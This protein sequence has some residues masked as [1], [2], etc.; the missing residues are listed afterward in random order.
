MNN[1]K[2]KNAREVAAFA[3]YEIRQN[4]CFSENALN[5]FLDIAKL[6]RRDV[7]LATRILYGTIQNQ[8][9]C[10]FYIRKYSKIRL[11]KIKPIVLDLLRMGVY[12]IVM[13][14]KI[15]AHAATSETIDIIKK[16][17]KKDFKAIGFANGILRSI[18]RDF[19]D[20]KLPKPDCENKE[21]Y[22][23][24]KYSHMEWFVKIL[25]KQ[26][27]QKQTELILKAN[28]EIPLTSVRV[29]MLKA[30]PQQI[31]KKLE[32][33]NFNVELHKKMDNIL[34][35]SGGN[36]ALTDVFKAGK[37][38][39][40]DTASA[41]AAY[42]LDVRENMNVIDCCS[43]PGGKTFYIAE[44]MKN[45]GKVISCDIYEQKLYKI[46]ENAE[47]L[48]FSCIKTYALDSQIFRKEFEDFA[49]RVMCDVPCSGMGIIRKK[50]EIRFKTNE[51]ILDLPQIQLNILKNCAKYV[52][53]DGIIVYST[54]TILERENQDVINSFLTVNKNFKL[55]PFE[56]KICGKT[57]GMITLL[58]H[59]HLTDGFFIAKLR[60]MT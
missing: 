32:Q 22:Y 10:D 15:P 26:Y 4:G 46:N 38:T 23:A 11:A 36:I 43:A 9:M 1:K 41:L 35:C 47:R 2:P 33:Q 30:T 29:N 14:D 24:L 57:N 56:H 19:T 16:F 54:C 7:A 60:R 45:T 3:L 50:P 13:L 53:K 59:I 48:G 6:T 55:E 12:Q 17:V 8:S 39:I 20:E 18:S 52:K 28:N 42:V 31:L 21:S 49:D 44:L 40:Q 34:L 37:I 51:E 58:P 25:I 27:G 5:H